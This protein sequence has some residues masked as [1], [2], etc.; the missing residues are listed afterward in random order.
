[1]EQT[2]ALNHASGWLLQHGYSLLVGGV[3]IETLGAP[4]PAAPL[5]LA[6]GALASAG[7]FSFLLSITLAALAA[8]A[9]DLVWFRLG[10]TRGESILGFLCRLS[11]EP[12][13]CVRLTHQTFDRYGQ[14]S[15]L[16]CKFVPGLSTVATPLAGS[17]GI[18][19][20]RFMAFDLAGAL[21]WS[22]VY[23][24]LGGIFHRELERVLAFLS[25]FGWWMFVLLASPL[26]GWLL[27]KY[28][29]RRLWL[30]S[31]EVER[32]TPET[33]LEMFAGEIPPLLID[34]RSA[35]AIERSGLKAAGALVLA[36]EQIDVHIRDLPP[37]A[38][39]IFYCS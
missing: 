10:Q 22:S 24:T 21:L 8:L 14:T 5:L 1:M 15:L 20:W 12:D 28:V 23:I 2:A 36:P 35:R 7:K 17:S 6:I 32:I 34:L 13:T 30:A 26:A 31:V 9:A 27:W 39:L 18:S 4:I 29:K 3:L 33:V 38:H 37:G 25:D 16:F 19:V 11:L